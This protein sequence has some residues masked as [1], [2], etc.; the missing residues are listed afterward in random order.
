MLLND[1]WKGHVNLLLPLI[2]VPN[3]YHPKKSDLTDIYPF[4][5]MVS[6]TPVPS[7]RYHPHMK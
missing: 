3:H 6:K 5:L 4:A 2:D 7:Q 1:V